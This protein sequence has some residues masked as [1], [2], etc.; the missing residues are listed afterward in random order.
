M[1]GDHAHDGVSAVDLKH[2]I[3]H[4]RA[5]HGVGRIVALLATFLPAWLIVEILPRIGWLQKAVMGSIDALPF[6]TTQGRLEVVLFTIGALILY[7]LAGIGSGI[8]SDLART[9]IISRINRQESPVALAEEMKGWL[10]EKEGRL[11][12][13]YRFF[14]KHA[15]DGRLAHNGLYVGLSTTAP[16]LILIVFFFF[17][18]RW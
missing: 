15:E 13:Q 6:V 9:R 17:Y 18:F 14:P 10:R 8:G 4:L 11:E 7:I 12:S 3:R 1:S 16:F 2:A 5:W